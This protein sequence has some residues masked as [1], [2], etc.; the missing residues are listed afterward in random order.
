[1]ASSKGKGAGRLAG[2]G[3]KSAS[4]RV[5]ASD[6]AAD[7]IPAISRGEEEKKLSLHFSNAVKAISHPFSALFSPAMLVFWFALAVRM[8]YLFESSSNPTFLAP[9]TDSNY[10]DFAAN[11]LLKTHQ[12]SAQFFFQ[13]FFYPL[14][15]SAVYLLSGSSIVAVKIIQAL[16]GSITC[17]LVCRLGDR[18]FD[19]RTGLLAGLIAALYGPMIFADGE[20]LSEGWAA[21]WTMLLLSTL[22]PALSRSGKE[23]I[24]ARPS[25]A[26]GVWRSA[27]LGV[28]FAIS[29][30]TRPTF[31]PVC[32][33]AGVWVLI[34]TWKDGKKASSVAGCAVAIA[35]AFTIVITPVACLFHEHTG[36]WTFLPTSGGV[37]LF[38]GNNPDYVKT[39]AVRPGSH[40]D[41]MVNQAFKE[42]IILE[43]DTEKS[44]YFYGKVLHY[45]STQPAAFAGGLFQKGIQLFSSREIPNN[46]DIYTFRDWSL[47]LRALVWKVE[48]FGFP[49][50]MLL[51]LAVAGIVL[52]GRRIPLPWLLFLFAYS[53]FLVLVH[54]CGRFRIPMMPV[55]ILL[56]GLGIVELWDRLSS[57]PE[58]QAGKPV[59][60]IKGLRSTGLGRT[61]GRVVRG[62]M[63]L[64]G[65]LPVAGAVLLLGVIGSAPGPFQQEKA[66]YRAE[67]YCLLSDFHMM[68]DNYEAAEN[69]A[70][71]AVKLAPCYAD[72]YSFLGDARMKLHGGDV[73]MD[74]YLQAIRCEPDH[75]KALNNAG[76][77]MLDRGEPVEAL[78]YFEQAL[79]NS[80]DARRFA[81]VAV[82]MGS[83]QLAMGKT[84]D[85]IEH[86]T[87][88]LQKQPQMAEALNDLGLAYARKGD[89]NRAVEC[90]RQ[91]LAIRPSYAQAHINL[92][93]VYADLGNFAEAIAHY[94]E[95]LRVDPSS[96]RAHFNL[97][98]T[99]ASTGRLDDAI[100]HYE[101][102]VKISPGYLKAQMY[103]AEALLS[104]GDY[105]QAVVYLEIAARARP[106]SVPVKELLER[107]YKLKSAAGK[108]F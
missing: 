78:R 11:N 36:A 13:P 90:Y 69:A 84:G 22:T 12:F 59:P 60:Q 7:L 35:L 33:L 96:S 40:Y 49:F 73:A 58:R 97:G 64:K 20:L 93:A 71:M 27:L 95:A 45:I 55:L 47:L 1:M 86:F 83:A 37:N 39:M 19:R 50:G 63:R 70:S 80:P 94:H 9:I 105:G 31:L 77:I 52:A 3:P 75:F 104:K 87:E 54:V 76:R 5:K 6:C 102:A 29:V 4:R 53:F 14:F 81:E 100:E 15:L 108:S 41:A 32:G 43:R 38:M 16:A 85:A 67:M 107:A 48:G 62:E 26:L 51:P 56:A 98:L 82:N 46:I 42:G 44:R 72:A 68:R 91:A 88:A 57:L 18:T 10:Y 2:R 23:N 66:D 79:A 99:L 101:Q 28:L 25:P 103:L 34:Q 8:L 30:L 61:F 92:G 106:D 17:A 21:L 89:F 74:S 24:P 65:L